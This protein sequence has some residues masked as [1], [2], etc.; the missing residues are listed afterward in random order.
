[1]QGLKNDNRDNP[2]V[3]KQLVGALPGQLACFAHSSSSS[4]IASATTLLTKLSP[5]CLLCRLRELYEKYH[6]EGFDLV[7]FPCNQFGGQAPGTSQEEREYAYKCVAISKNV[8]CAPSLS[9]WHCNFMKCHCNH[10]CTMRPGLNLNAPAYVQEVRL[11]VS[12]HGEPV[13]LWGLR[14]QCTGWTNSCPVQVDEPGLHPGC[15]P[16]TMLLKCCS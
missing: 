6:N 7:A 10:S 14:L 11:R 4:L 8:N 3:A 5:I 16:R 15:M 13:Q 9:D 12:S 2:Y 1:M